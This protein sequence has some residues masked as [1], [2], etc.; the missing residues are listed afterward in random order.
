MSEI[1]RIPNIENYVQEIKNGE[2]VLTPKNLKNFQGD[3]FVNEQIARHMII[4]YHFL[5]RRSEEYESEIAEFPEND[6]HRE[7][8]RRLIR[9]IIV[10]KF[11]LRQKFIQ[12][13]GE[14]LWNN[15]VLEYRALEY[16]AYHA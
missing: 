6:K 11:T 5:E 12:R 16:R 14:D 3:N 8:L 4:E 1:I 7:I 15:L 13:F 2:L 10:K 9:I